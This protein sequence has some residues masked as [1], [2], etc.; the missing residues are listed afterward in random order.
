[1][2]LSLIKQNKITGY[3]YKPTLFLYCYHINF[4]IAFLLGLYI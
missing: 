1:M 2:L 4:E 3:I